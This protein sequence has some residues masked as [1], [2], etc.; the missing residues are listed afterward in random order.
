MASK[1]NKMEIA[2]M[3]KLIWKMGLPMIISMVLQSVYNIVICNCGDIVTFA[4]DSM[5]AK[6]STNARFE[7]ERRNAR[8]KGIKT[9]EESKAS[10]YFEYLSLI[11]MLLCSN[12]ICAISQT[13]STV[14]LDISMLVFFV[15]LDTIL[16]AAN[17]CPLLSLVPS[18]S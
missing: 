8:V 5:Q 4:T 18:A 17:A 12:N 3:Y 10:L 1:Q 11:S 14:K 7:N 9:K 6:S 15:M 13:S 16:F 2:P